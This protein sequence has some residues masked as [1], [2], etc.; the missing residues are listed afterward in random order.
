METKPMFLSKTS[1]MSATPTNASRVSTWSRRTPV[2]WVPVEAEA[3]VPRAG[4]VAP[5]RC[6]SS[7]RVSLSSGSTRI[8]I[9]WRPPRTT[10][11]IAAIAVLTSRLARNTVISLDGRPASSIT[12]L[13][14]TP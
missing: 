14:M 1:A 3:P 2:A 13:V 11:R 7:S 5:P 4:T 10:N 12:E 8:D 9:S 6:R